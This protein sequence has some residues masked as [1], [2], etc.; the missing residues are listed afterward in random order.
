MIVTVVLVVMYTDDHGRGLVAG[1]ARTRA[2]SDSRE[3]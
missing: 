1:G 3:L 2:G